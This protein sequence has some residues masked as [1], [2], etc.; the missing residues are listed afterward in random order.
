[1]PLEQ[2]FDWGGEQMS[3]FL[4]KDLGDLLMISLNKFVNVTYN[5]KNI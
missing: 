5:S 4:G 1:M 3:L 2:L